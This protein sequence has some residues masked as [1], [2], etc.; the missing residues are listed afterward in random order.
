[1]NDRRHNRT[2]I[3]L[4]ASS[5]SSHILTA[6][7]WHAQSTTASSSTAARRCCMT[8]LL[9]LPA[10]C[11]QPLHSSKGHFHTRPAARSCACAPHSLS[12]FRYISTLTRVP[13]PAT[14]RQRRSGS[15]TAG[16]RAERLSARHP[17]SGP[18]SPAVRAAALRPRSSLQEEK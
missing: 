7:A 17:V 16:F 8:P 6:S 2:W 1:M 15:A 9:G 4:A 3:R 12:V 14:Q 13:Q 5:E 18:S 11:A 10:Q